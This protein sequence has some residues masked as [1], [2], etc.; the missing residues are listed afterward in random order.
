MADFSIQE[1]KSTLLKKS[2]QLVKI[3]PQ[4]EARFFRQFF[5]D[6]VSVAEATDV[7]T[8]KRGRPVLTDVQLH[9]DWDTET[10]NKATQGIIYPPAYRKAA[11]ISAYD[12]WTRN[13]GENDEL[14]DSQA[15]LDAATMISAVDRLKRDITNINTDLSR[16]E[17]LMASQAI[18]DRSVTLKNTATINYAHDASTKLAYNAANDFGIDTVDP[19]KIFKYLAS[20]VVN[21]GMVSPSVPLLAVCG[22]DV[23]E[24]LI[25]NPFTK[26]RHDI[27]DYEFGVIEQGINQGG[28]TPWGVVT[29]GSYKFILM[30]YG[31]LYNHPVTG[32]QTP[33]MPTDMLLV[34]P[35]KLTARMF[36]GGTPKWL[37]NGLV[38]IMKGK[39]TVQEFKNDKAFAIEHLVQSRFIAIPENVD[40]IATAVVI[41]PNNPN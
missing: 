11:V 36:Y 1:A 21:N 26:S 34:M 5:R 28:V 14:F 10:F 23:V 15:T 2:G 29:Y 41:N 37:P 27:K 31:V 18:L 6:D 35:Q 7:T 13:I 30:T 12:G 3:E 24:A 8:I 39:R 9:G 33:F 22:M 40:E 32:T 4:N 25:N 19:S 20:K 16:T 38:G 17:E